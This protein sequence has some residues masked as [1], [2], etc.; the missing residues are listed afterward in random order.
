MRLQ[1]FAF[2]RRLSEPE[3]IAAFVLR[4][5]PAETLFD[6][7]LQGSPLP[8]G[9]LSGFLKETIWYL[10]GCLHMA[11]HIIPDSEMSRAYGVPIP[12]LPRDVFRDNY[13]ASL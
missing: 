5:N 2:E 3:S 10:Y 8:V 6:E 12:R 11:N 4:D 7:G 1:A 9:D 13:L